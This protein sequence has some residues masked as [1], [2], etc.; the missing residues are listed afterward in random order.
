MNRSLLSVTDFG[1]LP[2]QVEAELK[3]ESQACCCASSRWGTMVAVGTSDG[4]IPV[5]DMMTRGE[6]CRLSWPERDNEMD[7]P[8]VTGLEWNRHGSL[9]T[10]GYRNGQ[11]YIWDIREQ[12]IVGS[13]VFEHSIAHISQAHTTQP[14]TLVSLEEGPPHIIGPDGPPIPLPLDLPGCVKGF[15]D[16]RCGFIVIAADKGVLLALHPETYTVLDAMQVAPFRSASFSG[17]HMSLL[18]AGAGCVRQVKLHSLTLQHLQQAMPSTAAFDSLSRCEAGEPVQCKSEAGPLFDGH[19]EECKDHAGPFKW[20]SA[21]LSRDGEFICGAA[22]VKDRHIVHVWQARGSHIAAVL[23]GPQVGMVSCAWHP[24]SSRL[25]LL[26]ITE[27][28]TLL[29]WAY[30]LAQNWDVYA[31]GFRILSHNE[32]Y[33]E[34]ETEFDLNPKVDKADGLQTDAGDPIDLVAI[35]DDERCMF[36]SDTEEDLKNA[37]FLPPLSLMPLMPDRAI[38]NVADQHTK[39]A[40]PLQSDKPVILKRPRTQK[41]DTAHSNVM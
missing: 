35:Q 10:A 26:S 22:V 24:D 13:A 5:F 17:K 36:E 34:S 1:G 23:E 8:A 3:P 25:I 39:S 38:G 11:M 16:H 20:C 19:I 33:V 40:T 21:D 12:K 41:V 6:A 9:L 18:L 32:E 15:L 30:I 7:Q 31:P 14:R 37:V 27:A 29:V 2:E 28:G 4:S